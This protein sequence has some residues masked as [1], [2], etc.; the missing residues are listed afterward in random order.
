[1]VAHMPPFRELYRDQRF[2]VIDKP[3]G[4]PVHAGPHG[5]ASVEDY[6]PLL[7]R[8]RDG[9]WLAHRLDSDTSGCLV[10]ALRRQALLAAQ[11]AFAEGRVAK[12]YWAVV[13]GLPLENAGTIDLP[14]RKRSRPGLGWRMV[15]GRGGDSAMTDWRV[16][17]RADD[18]TWLE[19][20]PRTGRTHQIRVHCASMGWPLLGDAIYGAG[21]GPLHLLARRIALPLSPPLTATAEPPAH[22]AELLQMHWPEQAHACSV[23]I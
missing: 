7:S 21:E 5:G 14:L 1:M 4:I 3:W 11:A 13:R 12:T 23:A 8:R 18:L 10:I 20:R 9:P 2:V 19:L 15:A 22:M 6:F 17:G 16:L